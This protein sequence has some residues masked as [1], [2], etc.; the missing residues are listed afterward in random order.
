VSKAGK[1]FLI[2]EDEKEK[3]WEGARTACRRIGGDLARLLFH[4]DYDLIDSIYKGAVDPPSWYFIGGYLGG[5]GPNFKDNYIW[6]TGEAISMKFQYWT[7][8]PEPDIKSHDCLVLS[9]GYTRRNGDRNKNALTTSPCDQTNR[10]K[11]GLQ[12]YICEV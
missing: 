7:N 8:I 1:A 10:A 3:T 6:N 12:G 9:Y 11:K 2:I 5:T 4:E